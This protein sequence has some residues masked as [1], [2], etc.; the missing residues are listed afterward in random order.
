ML[1]EDVWKYNIIPRLS[2]YQIRRLVIVNKELNNMLTE[3]LIKKYDQKC[4][5]D[6]IANHNRFFINNSNRISN[7]LKYNIGYS[8]NL[9]PNNIWINDEQEVIQEWLFQEN[10]MKRSKKNWG[11]VK[12]RICNNEK[13]IK[14]SSIKKHRLSKMHI[15]N[16]KN[17]DIKTIQENFIN[18]RHRLQ[19]EE[20]V[21]KLS[22]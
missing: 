17:F 21:Y 14:V 7:V 4:M 16:Y 15:K 3:Y 11:F 19:T 12:C 20:E 10:D 13:L 9:G 2:I 6:I 8:W 22:I 5:Y 18:E 1:V